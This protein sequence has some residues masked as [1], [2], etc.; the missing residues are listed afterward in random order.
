L[1]EYN[2]QTDGDGEKSHTE[3]ECRKAFWERK[4][5]KMILE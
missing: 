4:M 1:E 2:T 3:E 5:G